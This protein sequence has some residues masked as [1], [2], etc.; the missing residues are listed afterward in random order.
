[1]VYNLGFKTFQ[2]LIEISISEFSQGVIYTLASNLIVSCLQAWLHTS[3][4]LSDKCFTNL[5]N[6]K[7]QITIYVVT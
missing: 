2:S 7:L 3:V 6:C 5:T 4:T 1:M